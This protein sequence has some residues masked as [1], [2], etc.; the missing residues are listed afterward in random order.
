MKRLLPPYLFFL[1]VLAMLAVHRYLPL[2]HGEFS[3]WNHLGWLAILGGLGLAIIGKRLFANRQTNIKTFND[4]QTLVTEGP[5]RLSRNPMYL[6]F[7]LALIGIAIVLQGLSPFLVVLAFFLITDFWYIRFEEARM[8][9][10]FGDDY[11]NYCL[12]TRRW[13]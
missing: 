3:P 2:W 5:F 9:A 11:E 8:R 4:P 10:I 13:I 6:G 7:L 1:S 12:R